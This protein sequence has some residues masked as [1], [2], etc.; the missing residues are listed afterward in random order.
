LGTFCIFVF[1]QSESLLEFARVVIELSSLMFLLI[2]A[3]CSLAFLYLLYTH[4]ITPSWTKILIG[5]FALF[6][7][8]WILWEAGYQLLYTLI[9]PSSGVIARGIWKLLHRV[10]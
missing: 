6:F 5:F 10:A 8:I 2:Y 1:F 3:F 4:K 9:I 7:C